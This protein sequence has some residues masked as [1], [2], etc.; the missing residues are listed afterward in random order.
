MNKKYFFNNYLKF[1]GPIYA[2]WFY[3]KFNGPIYAK[4]F[5]VFFKSV[6]KQATGMCFHNDGKVS[7]ETLAH[8]FKNKTDSGISTGDSLFM[9][10]S[11][12]NKSNIFVWF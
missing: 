8:E 6:L 4:W 1:N 11:T 9:M 5:K 2:K 7:L 3:L 12:P 10:D